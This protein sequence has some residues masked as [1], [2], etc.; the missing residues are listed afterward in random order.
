[1]GVM[2]EKHRAALDL[3]RHAK[4]VLGARTLATGSLEP[5]S[6]SVDIAVAGILEFVSGLLADLVTA[7]E[8]IGL[9]GQEP[10]SRSDAIRLAPKFIDECCD[11]LSG[12]PPFPCTGMYLR[13]QTFSYLL[14]STD[15][16]AT[17]KCDGPANN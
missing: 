10:M 15:E 3:L 5:Y 9:I 14:G 16:E 13:A 11:I 12:E 6:Q 8:P 7:D 1:M 2:D 17:P 4:G